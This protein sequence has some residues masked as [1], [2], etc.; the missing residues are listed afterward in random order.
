MQESTGKRKETR[1]KRI[2]GQFFRHSGVE[3]RT[4]LDSDSKAD[5]FQSRKTTSPLQT[6]DERDTQDYLIFRL[7]IKLPCILGKTV[8]IFVVCESVQYSKIFLF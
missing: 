6:K 1:I 3:G 2:N 8:S 7:F 4:T 5:I